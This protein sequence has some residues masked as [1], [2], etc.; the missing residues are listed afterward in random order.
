MPSLST[1]PISTFQMAAR[2]LGLEE[3]CLRINSLS[4][5]CILFYSSSALHSVFCQSMHACASTDLRSCFLEKHST[6]LSNWYVVDSVGQWRNTGGW[7]QQ[8]HNMQSFHLWDRFRPKGLR[9]CYPAPVVV[10]CVQVFPGWFYPQPSLSTASATVAPWRCTALSCI[11]YKT[12]ETK[13][14]RETCNDARFSRESCNLNRLYRN[15]L[16]NTNVNK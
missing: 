5:W 2:S 8:Y 1:K 6:I 3:Q 12:N 7:F 11:I 16:E 4:H 13:F 15:R 14:V 10:S 9:A